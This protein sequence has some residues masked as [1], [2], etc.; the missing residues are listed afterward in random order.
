MGGSNTLFVVIA[1]ND[2]LL[3][4]GRAC[5]LT[6]KRLLTF[7]VITVISCWYAYF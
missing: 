1:G 2:T 6:L 7:I 3:L 5:G 4:T